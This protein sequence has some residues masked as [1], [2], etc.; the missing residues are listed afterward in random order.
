[1]AAPK[2]LQRSDD[3]TE[4]FKLA[5]QCAKEHSDSSVALAAEALAFIVW[6]TGE[7]LIL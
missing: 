5:V 2:S 1:M 3:E 7:Y 4:H 6:G